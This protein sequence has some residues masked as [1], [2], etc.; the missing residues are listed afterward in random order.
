VFGVFRIFRDLFSLPTEEE[1][2]SIAPRHCRV[3]GCTD[4]AACVNADGETCCWVA[5]DLCS[6]CEPDAEMSPEELACMVGLKGMLDE[7]RKEAA[8]AKCEI[9]PELE[10]LLGDFYAAG[11]SGKGL[12]DLMATE[13]AEAQ[14]ARPAP[15]KLILP[16]QE[17]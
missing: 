3:C 13:A 4:D 15:R 11:W 14:I 1:I 17:F 9:S 7:A 10:A 2:M 12:F 6:A 16:G 5:Q 8:F